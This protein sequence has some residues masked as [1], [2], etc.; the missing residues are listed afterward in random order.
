[1]WKWTE[2][3]VWVVPRYST[4]F[5]KVYVCAYPDLQGI[6]TQTPFVSM[7]LLTNVQAQCFPISDFRM[8][9]YTWIHVCLKDKKVDSNIYKST[10]HTNYVRLF[11]R[12]TC[13]TTC[14][15]L[16]WSSWEFLE[17]LALHTSLHTHMHAH[18]VDVVNS[19][20]MMRSCLPSKNKWPWIQ[21]PRLRDTLQVPFK[22]AYVSIFVWCICTWTHRYTTFYAHWHAC[23]R[24]C[25]SY[26]CVCVYIY[27]NVYIHFVCV[28]I[29]IYIYI[30]ILTHTHTYT[31]TNIHTYAYI[32][33]YTYI[34]VC[35]YICTYSCIHTQIHAQCIRQ[36]I[37]RTMAY[38][39]HIYMQTSFTKLHIFHTWIQIC[40]S[41]IQYARTSVH[42]RI[43]LGIHVSIVFLMRVTAHKHLF[44]YF[45]VF[46]MF[47]M[48]G[49]CACAHVRITHFHSVGCQRNSSTARFYM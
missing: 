10:K 46:T 5:M 9:M 18:N 15:W 31:H 47:S 3:L 30:Y 48:H 14:A 36:I 29:Y 23:V 34:Y 6:Q 17:F 4:C 22:Y 27:T 7:L 13:A 16:S 19:S 2:A 21:A 35:M 8:Q 42:A 49:E 33:I 26:L 44:I 38:L 32:H 12:T 1:M 11:V 40:H 37:A 28:C 25:I 41:N 39:V 45:K 24:T 20:L 43:H